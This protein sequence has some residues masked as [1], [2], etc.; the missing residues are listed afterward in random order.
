MKLGRL[1]QSL[2]F[3]L[4]LTGCNEP[5]PD[6]GDDDDDDDDVEINFTANYM[7]AQAYWYSRYNFGPLVMIGG[8]GEQWEPDADLVTSMIDDASDDESSA[9]APDVWHL[10]SRIGTSGDPH[11]ATGD[12]GDGKDWSDQLWTD[13]D[14]TPSLE[15]LGWV[16]MKESMWARQFHVDAH[17]GVPGSGDG[18]PG[19]QQRFFGEILMSEE[20]IQLLDYEANP[21]DFGDDTAGYYVLLA[22]VSDF[23]NIAVSDEM[24]H[25]ASNRYRDHLELMAAD[26]IPATNLQDWSNNLADTLYANRPAPT[27]LRET[28]YALYGLAWYG[29]VNETERENVKTEMSGLADT[30]DGMVADNLHD[31]AIKLR[32]MIEGFRASGSADHEASALAV[33]AEIKADFDDETGTFASQDVYTVELMGDLIGALNSAD[34]NLD[35]SFDV[36]VPFFEQ[37]VN[38]SGFQQAAPGLPAAYERLPNADDPDE[39]FHRWPDMP[40]PREG[41]GE[42]GIAPMY[43][44]SVTYDRAAGEWSEIDR[45]FHTEGAMHL[46]NE[47]I[48]FHAD[49]LEGFPALD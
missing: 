36:L 42:N 8:L 35:S 16:A 4:I 21:D 38:I 5:P 24:G 41:D 34:L 28:S 22:A 30:L 33:L 14:D 19:A 45:D 2:L 12:N 43:A 29:W 15:A 9:S 44:A 23:V 3:G 31:R 7:I 26:E 40:T 13:V 48:W 11:Y 10:I 47:M 39:L 18:I 32:G 46:A 25:S 17:F 1:W 6:T 49:E 20:F 27:T 37:V